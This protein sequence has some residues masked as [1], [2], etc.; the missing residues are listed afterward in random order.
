MWSQVENWIEASINERFTLTPQDVILGCNI[1]VLNL[2]I[3]IT[4]QYIFQTSRKEQPLALDD[5]KRKIYYSDKKRRNPV[6]CQRNT[7]KFDKKW[8]KWVS[9][10]TGVQL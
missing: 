1:D 6:S 10:L 5:I 9:L 4:K 2:I 7:N 8:N 3:L